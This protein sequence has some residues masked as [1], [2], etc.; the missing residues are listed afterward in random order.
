MG[1]QLR[2]PF[3][4]SRLLRGQP[5]DFESLLE[6]RNLFTQPLN[7]GLE[8]RALLFEVAL[9]SLQLFLPH[10]PFG[11]GMGLFQLQS[12]VTAFALGRLGAG[13][14]HSELEG[15]DR[16]LVLCGLVPLPLEINAEILDVLGERRFCSAALVSCCRDSCNASVSRARSARKLSVAS[17]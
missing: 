14:V 12:V 4:G 10:L 11:L 13:S 2:T 16:L 6:L 1:A 3:S 17:L 8:G 15:E 9:G 5:H 7:F